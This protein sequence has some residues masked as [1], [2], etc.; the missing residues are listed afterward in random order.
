LETHHL[1]TFLVVLPILFFSAIAA[2]L[3]T[4]LDLPGFTGFGKLIFIL[5]ALGPWVMFAFTI[6]AAFFWNNWRRSSWLLKIGWGV[7]FILPLIPAIFPLEHIYTS[8]VLDY[9][10]STDDLKAQ[11]QGVKIIVAIAYTFQILPIIISFPGGSMRAALR[12]RAVFP[13]SSLS[14]W[15]LVISAPFYSVLILMALV[16]V[17]QLAGN[18]LLILGT[19]LL[20]INPWTYV[21]FRRLLVAVSTPTTERRLDLLQRCTGISNLIGFLLI[22][23]Y[24]IS[25]EEIRQYIEVAGI[26][27][28]AVVSWSRTIVTTVLFCDIYLRMTVTQWKR[29]GERRQEGNGDRIDSLFGAIGMDIAKNKDPKSSSE[30]NYT[31]HEETSNNAAHE[32]TSINDVEVVLPTNGIDP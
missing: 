28:L 30:P 29:D 32:E 10:N 6:A 17:L 16:V 27:R 4:S 26:V 7:S 1:T 8:E 20:T 15:I 5:P 2:A 14:S 3:D 31:A 18:V 24:V 11:L 25:S 13:D 19:I 22:I 21:V 12:I 9:Y 23:L